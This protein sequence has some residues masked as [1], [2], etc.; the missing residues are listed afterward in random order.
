M[1]DNFK[2]FKGRINRDII[3]KCLLIGAA[4]G[5]A[6]VGAI[7]LS[8][9]ISEVSLAF[10]AIGI[11]AAPIGGL[12]SYLVLR[13]DDMEVARRIDSRFGLNERVQT[14]VEFGGSSDAMAVVQRED[15]QTRLAALSEKAM[16]F[17]RLWAYI[18]VAAA[19]LALFITA[20]A[21]PAKKTDTA[22]AEDP[23]PVQHVV[24][25]WE[26]KALDELIVYVQNADADEVIMKPKTVA[27]LQ[28]LVALLRDGVEEDSIPMFVGVTVTQVE[29]AAAEANSQSGLSD[30]EVKANN[31]L[32]AYVNTRLYEIFGI[33]KKYETP[34]GSDDPDDPNDGQ[35]GG[36]TGDVSMGADA[37]FFD[38]EKGYVKYDAVIGEYYDAINEAFGSGVISEDEWYDYISLYFKY[39]YGT[40]E[41]SGS[42]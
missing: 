12:L 32:R 22:V 33:G 38:P 40:E 16:P 42:I 15:V 31:D 35:G 39:L 23:P 36:G 25:E 18:A 24:S 29:N 13:T 6:A 2:R 9:K 7:L 19:A 27:A 20:V 14:M 4:C 10:C 37:M 21:L 1:Q 11:I 41:Q 26:W 5:F 8:C 34:G 3:I 17:T 30:A 28:A